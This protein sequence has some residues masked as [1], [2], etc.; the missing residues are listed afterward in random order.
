MLTEEFFDSCL[1]LN[2]KARA[3]TRL[4]RLLF[5]GTWARALPALTWA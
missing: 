1:A 2:F 4:A 5:I 3:R